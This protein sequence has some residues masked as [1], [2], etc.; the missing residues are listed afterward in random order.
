MNANCYVKGDPI[1]TKRLL[2]LDK[3]SKVL[4]KSRKDAIDAI[5]KWYEF[6]SDIISKEFCFLKGWNQ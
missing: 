5:N 2:E 4:A 6:E 1:K 3:R